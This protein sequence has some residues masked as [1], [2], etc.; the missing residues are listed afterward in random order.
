M[1]ACV[2]LVLVLYQE[3]PEFPKKIPA[4]LASVFFHT[5]LNNNFY[6][7][8][9][10]FICRFH[11][12]RMNFFCPCTTK[13]LLLCIFLLTLEHRYINILGIA[14]QVPWN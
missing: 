12:C 7:A 8:A 1:A 14:L 6:R 11:F 5:F 3:N 9:F 10:A 2:F 13:V 4:A